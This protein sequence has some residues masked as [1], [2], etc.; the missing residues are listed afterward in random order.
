MALK[1]GSAQADNVTSLDAARRAR[2]AHSS[3]PPDQSPASTKTASGKHG[4]RRFNTEKV[5]RLKAAIADGTYEIDALRVA[6][7]FIERE[8]NH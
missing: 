1:S 2:Q 8:G 7:K 4:N 6:D 5:E 3:D